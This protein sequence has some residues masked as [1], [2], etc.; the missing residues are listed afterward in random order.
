MALHLIPLPEDEAGAAQLGHLIRAAQAWRPTLWFLHPNHIL[1]LAYTKH[2]LTDKHRDGFPPSP[3]ALRAVAHFDAIAQME[4]PPLSPE[5][6]YLATVQ[7]NLTSLIGDIRRT[8]DAH[9]EGLLRA[10]KDFE[11]RERTQHQAALRTQ[12]VKVLLRTGR[13][14]LAPIAVALVG[15]VVAQGSQPFVPEKVAASTNEYLIMFAASLLSILGLNLA[16]YFLAKVREER[17]HRIL[18]EKESAVRL[19]YNKARQLINDI[20]WRPLVAAYEAYTGAPYT[21]PMYYRPAFENDLAEELAAAERTR[22]HQ[23]AFAIFVLRLLLKACAR[24]LPK[25]RRTKR[26]EAS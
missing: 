18:H 11:R 20:N 21:D 7:A 23:T 14:A 1:Y 10:Q 19:R 22:E 3:D 13:A 8:K 12:P 26:A 25:K 9:L 2:T 16:S 5:G 6:I 17:H 15:I 24:C 4:W